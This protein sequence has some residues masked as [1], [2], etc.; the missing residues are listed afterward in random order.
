MIDSKKLLN[1]LENTIFKLG[2][3]GVSEEEVKKNS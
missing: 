2:L 1:D 3:K